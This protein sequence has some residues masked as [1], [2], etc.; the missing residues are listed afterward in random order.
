LQRAK[1]FVVEKF[2]FL[3]MAM[4]DGH[5]V[6]VLLVCC[7]PAQQLEVVVVDWQ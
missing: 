5:V 2:C 4:D 1:A 3:V 7:A 6:I